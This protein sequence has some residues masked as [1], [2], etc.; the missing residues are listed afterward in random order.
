MDPNHVIQNYGAACSYA[1]AVEI[2]AAASESWFVHNTG[3]SDAVHR[4]Y[5]YR[6]NGCKD[7]QMNPNS[8]TY[9]SWWLTYLRTNADDY[10]L[11]FLD[12]DYMMLSKETFF[13][14]GGCSPWPSTCSSTQEISDDAHMVL[15]HASFANAMNHTNGTPMNFF[16]QQESYDPTLDASAFATTSRFKGITCEGCI[17][18]PSY[19]ALAARYPWVLDEMAA[20]NAEGGAF[21]LTSQG[22]SPNGSSTQILQ[23]LLTTGFAWLGYK[24]GSTVVWP[25]LEEDT[26]R[27]PIWPE[28]LIYPSQPLQTMVAG[29]ADLEVASG[30]YRREFGKCYQKGIY[31]GPCAAVVNGNSTAI[32][33]EPSWFTQTYRHIVTLNGGD[34]LLAGTAN[35]IGAPFVG[36][37]T[38]IGPG[39]ALLLTP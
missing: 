23:R 9:Q 34:V 25:D 39:A 15:A 6:P 14:Q 38:R 27:L 16:F 29:H 21:L 33:V 10:D 19:P 18:S 28:D 37:T 35:V 26:Y 4:V 31:F 5:G 3:Y 20:V 1:P 32:T 2:L 12:D 13:V 17:S 11:Y 36:G 30:V 24:E 7:W 22:V 8:P